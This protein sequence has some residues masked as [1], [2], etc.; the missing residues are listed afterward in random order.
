MAP[1]QMI[2]V[3]YDLSAR[4]RTPK[5]IFSIPIRITV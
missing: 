2:L 5:H 4:D 1:R 3:A